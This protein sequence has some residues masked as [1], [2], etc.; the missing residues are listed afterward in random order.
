MDQENVQSHS[1]YSEDVSIDGEPCEDELGMVH[2][3]E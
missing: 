3:P 1:I 2:T